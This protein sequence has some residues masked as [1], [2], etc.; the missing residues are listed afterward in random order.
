MEII[1]D[2]GALTAVPDELWDQMEHNFKTI[3]SH[4][5]IPNAFIKELKSTKAIFAE[6]ILPIENDI[7]ELPDDLEVD[8]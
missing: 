6:Y 2:R 3:F 1:P 5:D 8:L 7:N 4:G